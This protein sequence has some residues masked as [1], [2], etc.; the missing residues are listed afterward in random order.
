M[1]V[2]VCF[3]WHPGWYPRPPHPLPPRYMC[4]YQM[5]FF[6][7]FHGFLRRPRGCSCA[8]G[9]GARKR[10]AGTPQRNFGPRLGLVARALGGQSRMSGLIF[11]G[12]RSASL[13]LARP[14]K[15]HMFSDFSLLLYNIFCMTTPLKLFGSNGATAVAHQALPCVTATGNS[16]V[17]ACVSCFLLSY[18]K[19]ERT[20]SLKS[21]VISV[22]RFALGSNGCCGGRRTK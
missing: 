16:S 15:T 20:H 13:S 3:R 11:K 17:C 6:A 7:H 22:I 2:C 12:L 8:L 14:W 18:R 5:H 21:G 19:W 1:C 9:C 10:P 4:K